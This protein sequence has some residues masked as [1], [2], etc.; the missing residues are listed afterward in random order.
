MVTTLISGLV[1][2]TTVLLL[3]LFLLILFI[4]WCR[5]MQNPKVEAF[6]SVGNLVKGFDEEVLRLGFG[7]STR[8][9]STS[10]ACQHVRV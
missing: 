1:H 8:E 9:F 2:V 4:M 6:S 7:V 10:S 5:C 3:V